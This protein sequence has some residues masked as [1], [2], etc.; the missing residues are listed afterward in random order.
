MIPDMILTGQSGQAH[1]FT[2]HAPQ[3]EWNAVGGCYAFAAH[4]SGGIGASV[5]R[6]LYIGQTD[7][8]QRR[9]REHRD[10]QWAAAGRI[11]GNMILALVALSEA[12]RLAIEQ[13]LIRAY[14][15]RLNIL[16]V[17]Q[18]A[19]AQVPQNR[20]AGPLQQPRNLLFR[21]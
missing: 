5:T 6:I 11:G 19:L 18:N 12:A 10:D 3:T 8:F 14:Q 17:Q 13:D 20:L 9:M 2:C 7:S 15:P 16:H 21:S 1:R 4:N